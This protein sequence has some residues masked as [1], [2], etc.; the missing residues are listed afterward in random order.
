MTDDA[1]A[2][3]GRA[4]E[5]LRAA[6]RKGVKGTHAEERIDNLVDY[7]Q[8]A[9]KEVLAHR[10]ADQIRERGN[11]AMEMADADGGRTTPSDLKYDKAT[12]WYA[13]ADLIDPG[14]QR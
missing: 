2:E 1:M 6:L 13:A 4:R 12:T 14:A 8:M 10:L 9:L 5:E 3:L 11:N 7:H